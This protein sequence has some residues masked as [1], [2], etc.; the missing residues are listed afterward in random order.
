MY[1]WYFIIL[2]ILTL[3]GLLEIS[4]DN[5]R[6]HIYSIVGIVILVCF[7]GLKLRGGT[8]LG[9]LKIEYEVLTFQSVTAGQFEPLYVLWMV[10]FNSLLQVPFQC[11]YF[12]TALFNIGTKIILFKKLTP[13]LVP[14]VLI[15]FIGMYMERDNDGIR[16]GISCSIAY[17]GM[18]YLIKK[19]VR[20]F[21]LYTTL[22]SFIHATSIVFFLLFPLR[23]VRCKDK[24]IACIVAFFLAFPALKIS[25]FSLLHSLV[26]FPY[27]VAKIDRYI[28]A[29]NESYVG[30]AGYTT[31]L[32]FRVVILFLFLIFHSRMKIDEEKYYIF[33]NGFS[34]AI[35]LSLIF[36]DIIILNHR[37]PYGLR[38]LQAFIVPFFMTCTNNKLK[39]GM[40]Y[41]VIVLYVLVLLVRLV[42]RDTDEHYLYQSILFS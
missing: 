7:T 37:F 33:R 4:F 21:L 23:Y 17:I 35:I 39:K 27:I 8:D 19:N 1:C 29:G 9:N 38:E 36:H 15:Y 32:I 20:N 40:I 26:P 18:F 14:A 30:E 6:K 28:A 25:L 3:L 2:M 34:C 11:F 16:Q 42:I 12:V 22:A 10:L 24:W 41:S 5:G 31:G 13:Y